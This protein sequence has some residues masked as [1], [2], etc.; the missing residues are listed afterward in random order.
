MMQSPKIKC[1]TAMSKM[2]TK[3]TLFSALTLTIGLLIGLIFVRNLEVTCETCSK[4]QVKSEPSH[5]D[6]MVSPKEHFKKL[7]EDEKYTNAH[8][9]KVIFL[10]VIL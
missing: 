10:F 7:F 1:E 9:L 8:K 5:I 2:R 4:I 6:I 3:L